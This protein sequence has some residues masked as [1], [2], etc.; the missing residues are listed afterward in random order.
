[1]QSNTRTF[2]GAGEI[3][4]YTLLNLGT[5][6]KVGSAWEVFGRINNVFD[7]KY[8]TAGALAE[9]PFNAAG[10]FQTNSGNW[11]RETAFGPGAPRSAFVGVRLSM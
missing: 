1:M 10:T 2:L 6:V 5:R 8:A 7:K 11:G 3:K 9:N 4:A